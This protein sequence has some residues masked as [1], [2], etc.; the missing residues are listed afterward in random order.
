MRPGW[1]AGAGALLG[2]LLTATPWRAEKRQMYDRVVDVPR[3]LCFYGE[4]AELPAPAL[5]AFRHALNA[6]YAAELGEPLPCALSW[7]H[8][9]EPAAP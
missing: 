8:G 9:P 2:R 4:G 5:S 3:L 1:I 7:A 6:H